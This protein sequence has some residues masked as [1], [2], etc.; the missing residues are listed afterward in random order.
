M[1]TRRHRGCGPARRTAAGQTTPMRPVP[2]RS[3]IVAT[4][5]AANSDAAVVVTITSWP[6]R[7]TARGLWRVGATSGSRRMAT[8]W[9]SAGRRYP[10]SSSTVS[11]DTPLWRSCSTTSSHDSWAQGLVACA[12][13]PRTVME[14]ERDRRRIESSCR[15]DRSWASSTTMCS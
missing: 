2:S 13:S 5:T 14:P 15:G 9:T 3:R 8:S 11:F 10:S 6:V 7:R 4:V 12:R 1:P